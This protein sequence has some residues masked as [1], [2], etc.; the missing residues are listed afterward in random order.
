MPPKIT[1]DNRGLILLIERNYRAISRL[2]ERLLLEIPVMST[3]AVEHLFKTSIELEKLR[4]RMI[5]DVKKKESSD[6]L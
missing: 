3:D 2:R 5:R 6:D 1:K 4:S